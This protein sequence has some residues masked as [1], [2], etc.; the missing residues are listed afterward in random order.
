MSWVRVPLG[1]LGE[2]KGKYMR[3]IIKDT[4]F[5][6]TKKESKELVNVCKQ[7]VS[8]GIYAVEK[9]DLVECKNETYKTTEELLKAVHEYE[10][11]GFKVYYNEKQGK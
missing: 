11:L 10:R 3:V 4:L 8:C 1:A 9:D 5:M 2:E 7:L 6:A